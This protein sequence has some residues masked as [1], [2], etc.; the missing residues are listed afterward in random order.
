MNIPLYLIDSFTSKL[1]RGNPAAVCPLGKW[2]D[3]DVMQAIAVENNLS[4]TAFF[5]TEGDGFH[6]RWF[7]PA[8]EVDLCGHATLASAFVLFNDTDFEQQT[9]VF[10][11]RSGELRVSRKENLMYLD[12]PAAPITQPVDSGQLA[13]AL[14]ATPE[15]TWDTGHNWLAVFSD[16]ETVENLQ[17]DF[18][19]IAS[20]PADGLIVS[21]A[22]SDV[23]FIS[24]YFAPAKGIN[25][26]PV[27]GSTHCT[28][29]PYWGEKLGKTK[30]S[31]RQV[32]ERGGD[33]VCEVSG[34]RV[35]IG[36]QAV[37]FAKGEIAL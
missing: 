22:A 1:F 29:A 34:D 7:T 10:E 30:L 16:P 20:L 26:D 31:A 25:E 27:T 13:K 11:S 19:G 3:D 36:G 17:P 24:R 5:V 32:S 4:E 28:L 12:F 9:I 35:L 8:C 14:G 37:L 18:A 15:N 21:A 23:D 6:I 2:L 33:L